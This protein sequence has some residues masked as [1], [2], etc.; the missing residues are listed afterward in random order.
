MKT[1]IELLNGIGNTQANSL[2]DADLQ[3]IDAML[4]V[5]REARHDGALQTTL[6]FFKWTFPTDVYVEV[7][8]FN[9][10]FGPPVGAAARLHFFVAATENTENF[11][12]PS[13]TN[14][15]KATSTSG[16]GDGILVLAGQTLEGKFT[17]TGSAG[18]EG[19]DVVVAVQLRK[20]V[21]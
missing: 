2:C 4:Y 17:Q 12:L 19:N 11:D 20:R 10:H 1:G 18:T 14:Y 3:R 13:T 5:F 7:V 16:S 15:A 21:L 6:P 8:E 9:A